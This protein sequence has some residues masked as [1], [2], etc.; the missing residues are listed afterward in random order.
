MTK[1]GSA[2]G[3]KVYLVQLHFLKAVVALLLVV[4]VEDLHPLVSEPLT[5]ISL[6]ATSTLSE[7]RLARKT[8]ENLPCPISF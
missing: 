2:R 1:K 5:L 4:H 3:V 7:R 6:R 8:N